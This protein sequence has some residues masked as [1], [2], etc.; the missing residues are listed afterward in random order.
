MKTL[1][2]RSPPDL[3]LRYSNTCSRLAV[4]TPSRLA[5]CCRLVWLTDK[6]STSYRV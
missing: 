2:R 5:A 6:H 1:R 3:M 4:S